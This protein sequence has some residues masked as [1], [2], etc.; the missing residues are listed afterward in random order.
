MRRI[1]NCEKTLKKARKAIKDS[2]LYSDKQVMMYYYFFKN[3]LKLEEENYFYYIKI[4]NDILN[5][6][7]DIQKQIIVKQYN[8]DDNGK[9]TYQNIALQT[10][11]NIEKIYILRKQAIK[12]ILLQSWELMCKKRFKPT[13][14]NIGLTKRSYCSLMDSNIKTVPELLKY[15]EE[16]L[17]QKCISLG[18]KSIQD[19]KDRLEH[20][21][22]YLKDHLNENGTNLTLENIGLNH[23]SYHAL[24]KN[25]I[26]TLDQLLAKTEIELL[27]DYIFIGECS[28]QNI[29]ERLQQYGLALMDPK[30]KNI[31]ILKV[32]ELGL[33][34]RI[35]NALLNNDIKT[36][37]ILITYT[38]EELYQCKGISKISINV[39]KETLATFQLS[40]KE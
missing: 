36:V 11:V 8:L 17:D 20:Y 19:I 40:I 30:N 24:K 22:L 9:C 12:F 25:K 7:P 29:K 2:K 6:L 23:R 37:E 5:Q 10:G 38:E 35:T 16:Q 39:I 32:I 28:I 1:Y 21:G 26:L 15:T 13:L 14:E 27:N 4:L 34:K 3:T 18:E 33:P 31:H